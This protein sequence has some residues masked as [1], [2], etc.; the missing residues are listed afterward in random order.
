[1]KVLFVC[2][3]NICRSPMAEALMRDKVKKAGLSDYISVSSAATG[4]WNLGDFPHEGTQAV[5]NDHHIDFNGI[6]AKKINVQDFVSYDLIIGMDAEN[7]NNLHA[8]APTEES[9]CKIHQ[10]LEDF[11][12]QEVPDP[13]YTGNFEL[14]YELINKGTDYW[15]D[16]IKKT[17]D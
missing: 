3:G 2:L 16:K 14:T 7:I 11:D 6:R 15:L 8:I 17:I 4:S 9:A 5:L 12:S 10:L 1:M 13:Y